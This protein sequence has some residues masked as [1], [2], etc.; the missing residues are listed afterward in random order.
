MP[1]SGW[2]AL[3]DGTASGGKGGRWGAGPAGGRCEGTWHC[4]RVKMA[5]H[6][7][8]F[9]GSVWLLRCRLAA[10][11]PYPKVKATELAVE[12]SSRTLPEP[13]TILSSPPNNRLFSRWIHD[14]SPIHRIPGAVLSIPDF[15]RIPESSA[16]FPGYPRMFS[17]RAGG[18]CRR[19]RRRRH[20]RRRRTAGGGRGGVLRPPPC[21]RGCGAT[22]GWQASASCHEPW[23]RRAYSRTWAGGP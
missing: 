23:R 9:M 22:G 17:R 4:G 2:D 20:E 6:P 3:V 8:V 16:R 19:P 10:D 1:R 18:R 11:D 13:S 14:R 7:T 21:E 12:G 5:T 15:Q